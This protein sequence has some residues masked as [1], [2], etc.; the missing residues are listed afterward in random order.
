MAV[1]RFR[2]TFEDQD[3]VYRDVELKSN[4]TFLDLHLIIQKAIGFDNSKPASLFVSDDFWRKGT[5]MVL[6][7]AELKEGKKLMTKTKLS[8]FIDDPHQK[9]VYVFDPVANWVLL[10]ELMKIVDDDATATY[11]QVIKSVGVSPKQYKNNIVAPIVGEEDEDGDLSDSDEQVKMFHSEEG[12]DEDFNE[13]ED[14]LTEGDD[15][16][17]EEG[18]EEGESEYLDGAEDSGGE[19]D[20]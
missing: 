6:N 12:V 14:A 13:D 1:Y 20:Y 2:V 17:S 19:E 5:E 9:F 3:E 11:P 4:S 10:V 16:E 18:E 8:G 7:E 15:E